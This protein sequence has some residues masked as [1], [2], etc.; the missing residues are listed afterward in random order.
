MLLTPE[1]LETAA[2]TLKRFRIGGAIIVMIPLLYALVP[3]FVGG[4]FSES[5]PF[6]T[7]SVTLLLLVIW[8]CHCAES[9]IK[10]LRQGLLATAAK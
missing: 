10:S 9:F 2:R 3:F 8:M 4:R 1:I 5:A 6:T 7:I